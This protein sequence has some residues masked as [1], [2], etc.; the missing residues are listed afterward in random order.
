MSGAE[1]TAGRTAGTPGKGKVLPYIIYLIIY[2]MIGVVFRYAGENLFPDLYVTI[3]PWVLF[4]AYII[5]GITG[6]VLC[7]DTFA[8]GIRQWNAHPVKNV[9]FLA[10]CGIG[11]LILPTLAS[12]P[13]A[14]LYPDY[15]SVNEVNVAGVTEGT[16]YL[17]S[18]LVLAVLGPVCEEVVFRILLVDKAKRLSGIPTAVLIIVSSVI[19]AAGHMHDPTLP[20]LLSN[21]PILFTGLIFATTFVLSKNVTIPAIVHVANNTLAIS[22]MYMAAQAAS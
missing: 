2:F 22:L 12:I 11:N 15:E 14:L 9:L 21:L 10:G 13:E 20:E 18:I 17:L 5:M 3:K 7:R 19:F 6:I 16:P 1:I 4:P 8:E